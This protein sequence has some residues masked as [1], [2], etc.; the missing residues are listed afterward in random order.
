MFPDDDINI[1]GAKNPFGHVFSYQHYFSSPLPTYMPPPVY[2][3]KAHDPNHHYEEL[4]SPSMVETIIASNNGHVQPASNAPT[5]TYDDARDSGCSQFSQPEADQQMMQ[6]DRLDSGFSSFTG[7]KIPVPLTQQQLKPSVKQNNPRKKQNPLYEDF[8]VHTLGEKKVFDIDDDPKKPSSS[9]CGSKLKCF[10]NNCI[11]PVVILLAVA[12]IVLVLLMVFGVVE[13]KETGDSAFADK[14]IG[15][16][17]TLSPS[18]WPTV[19]PSMSTEYLLKKV[20]EQQ[21]QLLALTQKIED[22]ENAL[23]GNGDD[24]L[25]TSDS[26]RI[27]M[28]SNKIKEL[29]KSLE[30]HKSSASAQFNDVESNADNALV[31]IAT[32][33][34]KQNTDDENINARVDTINTQLSARIDALST[35]QADISSK[36]TMLEVTDMSLDQ[37]LMTVNATLTQEVDTVSKMQGPRGYNGSKGDPGA[38][39]LSLCSY[40]IAQHGSGT[41]STTTDVTMTPS[42]DQVVFGVTCSTKG[43]SA[44]ILKVSNSPSAPGQK[45][46]TCQCAGTDDPFNNSPAARYCYLHYWQCPVSS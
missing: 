41:G 2:P 30:D 32:L 6:L 12:A 26:T 9:C 4:P 40:E 33:Q 25:N 19:D 3:N 16:P 10:R 1:Q 31:A 5:E 34:Q 22:L 37:K 28:N 21:E 43:G 38:G 17:S 20:L 23:S 29:E 35:S 15:R 42:A 45:Q 46:Y 11:I 13:Q 27:T 44:Y 8:S 14:V 36:V 18:D 39:D 24:P 7:T